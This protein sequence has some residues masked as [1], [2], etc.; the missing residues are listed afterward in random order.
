LLRVSSVLLAELAINPVR[1]SVG[2]ARESFD[3]A[4]SFLSL[5]NRITSSCGVCL[6]LRLGYA[7]KRV[8]SESEEGLL[9]ISVPHPGQ[10]FPLSLNPRPHLPHVLRLE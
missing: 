10:K 3:R 1:H 9:K 2:D 8:L 7:N 6:I 4:Q 5:L